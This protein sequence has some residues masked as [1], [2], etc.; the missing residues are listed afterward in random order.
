MSLLTRLTISSP[1]ALCR[2]GQL[3]ANRQ[4]IFQQQL[5]VL[6]MA[7]SLMVP[8]QRTIATSVIRRDIDSA[9]KYIGAGAATVGVAGAGAGIG[10]VFGSLVVAYARNPSLKQQ[11]FSYA[12]LGFALSEAMGLFC[13]MMAFIKV[14]SMFVISKKLAC[15]RPTFIRT[16]TTDVLRIGSVMRPVTPSNDNNQSLIPILYYEKNFFPPSFIRHLEWLMK[17][18][19]LGQDAL[20]VGPPGPTRRHLILAYLELTRKPYQYLQLTRDT[21]DSDIKQRR[22]IQNKTALFINQAAVNAAIHGHTLVL[23]GLE[24]AERNVLPILNNLLENREMNLD[25]GQFLVSTQRFDEL[26]K[27]YTKEQLDQLNFI[28][29][30]EDF[31]VIALTLP[32]LPEYRGHSL[33]PPLRSRFQL[34][35]ISNVPL[36]FTEHTNLLRTLHPNVEGYFIENLLSLAS[37]INST[38]L[39]TLKLVHFPFDRL[40]LSVHLAELIPNINLIDCFHRIYPYDILYKNSKESKQ[41]IQHMFKQLAIQEQVE[42]S[43]K[44]ILNINRQE[45]KAIVDYEINGKKYQITVP[46]HDTSLPITSP[47]FISTSYH[48]QLLSDL[49]LSHAIGDI[50]LVGPKGCG[51][52]LIIDQF[53]SLL[54]YP[55]EYFVLYKDL[56]ARELLQQ[57]ITNENGDTLWQ[58]TPLVQAAIHGRLLVLDGIH[59]LNNDTLVSLQRL[60]QDRELFLPDGTRLLR[61]DRYDHLENPSKNIRRIHPSFRIIALAEPPLSSNI[62]SSESSSIKSSSE[63]NWLNA[64]TLNLFLYHQMRS[65]NLTEERQIVYSYLSSSNKSI[66][67]IEHLLQFVHE[68][69]NSS[70]TQL[71][72]VAQSLSTRNVLRIAKHLKFNTSNYHIQL[73]DQLIR[74]T[75]APFLPRLVQDAFY[76]AL[77]KSGLEVNEQTISL[78]INWKESIMN[79]NKNSVKSSFEHAA[80]V[81][82][83]IFY[84]NPIH[85]EIIQQMHESFLL[86][87]HL[88]LI[89]PQG[90]AKNRIVDHYLQTLKLPREYIQLH[91]DTTVQSLTIQAS[92]INGR[93]IY[94]DSPL[95]KAIK[96]GSIAVIDEADKAPTNVTGILKSLIESG[97]MFLS[98]GRRVYP[99]DTGNITTIPSNMII[100]TH[101]NFRMIVLA[102]RPGFP[103]LGNDLG[104]HFSTFPILNPPRESEIILL[105]NFGPNIERKKLEQLVDVF[106]ELRQLSI[107]GIISYPYS[108]RELVSIVK[109][110]NMFPNDSLADVIRN[111]FDLDNYNTDIIDRLRSILHRYGIPFHTENRTVNLAINHPLKLISKQETWPIM[112]IDDGNIEQSS[113]SSIIL[114]EK[115]NKS[116]I[117][118]IQSINRTD[119][120]TQNFS[121]LIYKYRLP[122]DETSYVHDL[123]VLNENKSVLIL[124]GNPLSLW[125]FKLGENQAKKIDLH[126]IFIDNTNR[127]TTPNYQLHVIPGNE[128]QVV[129]GDLTSQTWALVDLDTGRNAFIQST[130]S[131]SSPLTQAITRKFNEMLSQRNTSISRSSFNPTNGQLLQYIHNYNSIHIIDFIKNI[132]Q[133]IK[134]PFSIR[135]VIPFGDQW[136]LTDY[137]QQSSSSYLFNINNEQKPNISMIQHN[138][139]TIGLANS[140]GYFND[141][142]LWFSSSYDY[143]GKII[144]NTNNNLI[145][146]RFKRTKIISSGDVSPQEMYEKRRLQTFINK[147]HSLI[148]SFYAKN[149]IDKKFTIK[150]DFPDSSILTYME[151]IDL[152]NHFITYIPIQ[153]SQQQQQYS[154]STTSQHEWHMLIKS[155]SGVIAAQYNDG[156]LITIDAHANIHQWEIIPSHLQISLDAWHKNT[157]QSG[158]HSLDIEYLKNGKTDLSGPKHGKVDPANNPHVGGNQWAGGS[159]GRDT[160]GLGGIGGPYRLD[161]GHQV[162]QVPDDV[163][164]AVPEHIRKAARELGQKVFKERLKEIEMSEYEHD[165]Y[166]GYLKKISSEIKMLRSIIES[167]EAKSHDRQWVRHR[168]TGDW[169]ERKLIEG[170]IGEKSIYKYRADVPPEP[171][172][173]Q[174][175]AKRLRL[176]VD[177][178]ASM[179]R[180]NGVDNRLE[181]QCECVLMF[182]ESLAGFEHKFVYDIVGHSGDEHSIELVRKHQPP[183]NN[184]ERLK[185]LKLMHTHTMFCSSGDNTLP[186]LKTAI[187]ALQA[188]PDDTVDERFVI[189]ISDANF[190]RYG[191]SPKVFGKML[192]SNENVQCFAMFIGSLG[193]QAIHLQQ[194][195]PSGKGFV[196]LETSQIPKVL[197]TIFTSDVLH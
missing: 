172:S 69:R 138:L 141:N 111:V 49:I 131:S 7:S 113:S 115:S 87:E 15:F 35:D 19:K 44:K 58:N 18:D 9:A 90:V 145:V 104:D 8:S 157:N 193:Q 91:R 72:T 46:A 38:D 162:Y 136:I 134:L 108:L 156:S 170:I 120:R 86:G 21:T 3:L 109:H 177:L 121:E 36:T 102:N 97:S 61:H 151:L 112:M 127:F 101:P 53:A 197:K 55:I 155:G 67:A 41:V 150:H 63:Q 81:P 78:N 42:K 148:A 184:K 192:Q 24:K 161:S 158:T 71:K 73:R 50:C 132:S 110:L 191:L 20:F 57:R 66:P 176:V 75:S 95:I 77:N 14:S 64:E 135:H 56:S 12:I 144:S 165:V 103:F 45:T 139:D 137:V 106:T 186:A 126:S 47:T 178:S 125:M 5:P 54:N 168:T 171:G 118:I 130:I 183:K 39:E 4:I 99:K 89:G 100:R 194:N 133:Q 23:D 124:T 140:G 13:L 17:K 122:L 6:S 116:S 129:V 160:A 93:I 76:E 16:V 195:L 189:V 173:P 153:R 169:D 11:L 25:N 22:E 62:G 10:T 85:S 180:F 105:Q 2:L 114:N 32:P 164:A 70:E 59:R 167:L 107:D 119:L 37:L 79:N 117:K 68:L 142:S 128:Q 190:D 196:C 27:F 149:E 48:D 96:E 143:L 179:Y 80:K 146:E 174:T 43:S 88:L 1:S 163:K 30:H 187:D 34:R 159:G 26:L 152:K 123:K 52:S 74:Q 92:I 185:L 31:R 84:E 83:T 82:F 33:D 188:E 166:E 181:R 175:K 29:V 40:N 28:R 94:E 51:K 182:L 98:D 65:L 154:R 147:Q 60:I